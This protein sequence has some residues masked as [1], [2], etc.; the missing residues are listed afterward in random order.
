MYNVDRPLINLSNSLPDN[1]VGCCNIVSK[2][3]IPHFNVTMDSMKM[4]PRPKTNAMLFHLIFTSG[5]LFCI[6][7]RMKIFPLHHK[8]YLNRYIVGWQQLKQ[9]NHFHYFNKS[10]FLF[11]ESFFW[12][13]LDWISLFFFFHYLVIQLRYC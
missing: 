9:M 11:L 13:K 4:F 1:L 8:V 10:I 12:R 2:L 6:N 5:S 3:Y 7:F